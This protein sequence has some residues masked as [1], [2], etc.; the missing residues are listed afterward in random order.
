MVTG[1]EP[2][3]SPPGARLKSTTDGN[4]TTVSASNRVAVSTTF[5]GLELS[6]DQAACG[7]NRS[8]SA[9]RITTKRKVYFLQERYISFSSTS[10]L[11]GARRRYFVGNPE[12]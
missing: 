3:A 7:A 5:A 12:I 4:A 10:D 6:C 9:V 1:E 11:R 2:T 8:A